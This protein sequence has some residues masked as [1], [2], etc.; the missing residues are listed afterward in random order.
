MNDYEYIL[1][2]LKELAQTPSRPD[3]AGIGPINW[4]LK[5]KESKLRSYLGQL[6][7]VMG[8]RRIRDFGS[9]S[10]NR[11]VMEIAD[12]IVPGTHTEGRLR[13]F[14][15]MPMSERSKDVYD[16]NKM[17]LYAK[18]LTKTGLYE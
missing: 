2:I 14:Y 3:T 7:H 8:Q 10:S 16:Q 12:Q 4:F 11:R 15:G 6:L 5:D 1:P 17:R 18:F 9:D 13:P